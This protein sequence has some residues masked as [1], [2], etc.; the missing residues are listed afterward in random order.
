VLPKVKHPA[1]TSAISTPSMLST[2]GVQASLRFTIP[3]PGEGGSPS[4]PGKGVSVTSSADDL[5]TVFAQ[6]VNKHKMISWKIAAF[7]QSSGI[8]FLNFLYGFR[9]IDRLTPTYC[10]KTRLEILNFPSFATHH[11][12]ILRAIIPT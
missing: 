4:R 11:T 10:I 6:P 3:D 8:Y 12:R 7:F 5:A 9:S 2:W 1:G